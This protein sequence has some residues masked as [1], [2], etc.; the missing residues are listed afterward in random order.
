MRRQ[1]Y[2]SARR[3]ACVPVCFRPSRIV[4]LAAALTAF[5]G[6]PLPYA[7]SKLEPSAAI[8]RIPDGTL[9]RRLPRVAAAIKDRGKLM[10]LLVG[11]CAVKS[12]PQ[13]DRY[14]EVLKAAVQRRVAG[15]DVKIIDGGISAAESARGAVERLKVTVDLDGP[16]LVLWHVGLGDV[17]A[18]IPVDAFLAATMEAIGWLKK[19]G[20]DI[21]VIDLPYVRGLQPTVQIL[22]SR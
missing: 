16:D 12:H 8:C 1:S 9:W 4:T 19:S 14:R 6:G 15:I 11:G 20:L 13:S 2:L 10:V 18:R 21:L 7:A 3:G 17:F 22:D 5:A